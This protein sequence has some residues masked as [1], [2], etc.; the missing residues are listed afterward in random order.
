MGSAQPL[1]QR[2]GA[3]NPGPFPSP[4]WL[5]RNPSLCSPAGFLHTCGPSGNLVPASGHITQAK[6][7]CSAPF[8]RPLAAASAQT[9]APGPL[10]WHRAGCNP[11]LRRQVCCSSLR[12][13]SSARPCALDLCC[14]AGSRAK[15]GESWR[16]QRS[17]NRTVLL[18][19]RGFAAYKCIGLCSLSAPDTRA[20]LAPVRAAPWGSAQDPGLRIGA[21]PAA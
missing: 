1:A 4:T 18:L 5:G 8:A 12:A 9:P 10:R 2:L 16:A 21:Q 11:L 14:A 20:E 7:R 13:C 19:G 3:I 17:T 6:R 15:A